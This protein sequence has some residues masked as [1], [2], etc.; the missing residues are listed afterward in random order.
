MLMAI[1]M[2]LPGVAAARPEA[3]LLNLIND[4]RSS[5]RTCAGKRLGPVKPLAAENALVK[6]GMDAGS[7]VDDALKN[8]GYRA[9]RAQAIAVSGVSTAHA[10]MDVIRQPYCASL[11]NDQYASIG[12]AR[13]GDTWRIVLAQPLLSPGLGP[14]EEAAREVLRLVNAA[15]AAPRTCGTVRFPAAQPLAWNDRLAAAS[16]SHSHDM[17]GKNYFRHE[18]KDGSAVADR[19]TRAGYKWSQIGENIAAGQGSARDVV[20]GWLSSPGHCANIMNRGF[21]EMGAAFAVDAKSDAGIYWTQVF[22][23]A[24]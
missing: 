22:G 20:S 15:R 21:R 24:R 16:L 12:I 9:A 5:A 14:S 23:A 1:L 7:A 18:G 2:A 6:A 8:A 19:A 3:E 13:A 4:Y 17:A 11:L 10:V